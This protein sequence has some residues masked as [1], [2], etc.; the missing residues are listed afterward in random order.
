MTTYTL[1]THTRFDSS[2]NNKKQ[3]SSWSRKKVEK[4]ADDNA[5]EAKHGWHKKDFNFDIG[6]RDF[7]KDDWKFPDLSDFFK[8]LKA[9]EAD[10]RKPWS[11]YKKHADRPDRDDDAGEAPDTAGWKS[12]D[13]SEKCAVDLDFEHATDWI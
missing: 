10:A 6:D 3:F 11:K 5:V 4:S 8:K 1:N 2:G 9:E 13:H 7:G 12:P